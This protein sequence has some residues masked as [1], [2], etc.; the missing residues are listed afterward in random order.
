MK[1]GALPIHETTEVHK[2]SEM[3]VSAFK[4]IV[5]SKVK[6]SSHSCPKRIKIKSRRIEQLYSQ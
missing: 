6:M 3:K 4:D 5:A 1:C 2:V